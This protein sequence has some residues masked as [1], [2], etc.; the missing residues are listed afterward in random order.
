MFLLNKPIGKTPYQVILDFK[1]KNPKYQNI[2]LSYAGRL[3]P[4]ATGELLILEGEENKSRRIHEKHDKEY[5]VDIL[6]GIST[7]SYDLMGI[8]NEFS[9]HLTTFNYDYAVNIIQSYIGIYEQAYPPYSSYKV[10]GK[11]LFKWARE[12]KLNEID[13]PSKLV[14]I[15]SIFVNQCYT[16][17]KADLVQ[18]VNVIENIEGHFRQENILN[19]WSEIF[20]TMNN[21]LK[22]PVI[23]ITVTCSS[24][25]YMR[26]LVLDIGKNL[27]IPTLA[28]HIHRNKVIIP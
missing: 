11:P 7:D 2:T 9:D 24:G 17:A 20:N 12:G 10:K 8:V 21:S 5:I 13:C 15:K 25:T 1:L 6:F 28:M 18:K 4:M 22:L 23:Q 19:R 14:E 3:D 27:S 26:Q 16:I